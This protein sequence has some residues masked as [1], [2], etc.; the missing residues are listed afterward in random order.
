M[1]PSKAAQRYQSKNMNGHGNSEYTKDEIFD[2]SCIYAKQLLEK[3]SHKTLEE[4]AIASIPK[5]KK[6]DFKLGKVLGRGTFGVVQE[7]VGVS[8]KDD[9]KKKRYVKKL[10]QKVN[11]NITVIDKNTL[12][13]LCFR[14][15]GNSRFAIK[16]LSDEVMGDHNVCYR[17]ILD[18]NH[19]RKFLSIIDHPCILKIRAISH[20][21]PFNQND[22]ILMD[23]LEETLDKKIV[24]WKRKSMRIGL[25][26]KKKRKFEDRL[27]VAYDLIS[28]VSYLHSK[29]ILHRDLKPEN[30]GFGYKS[31]LKLFDFG[32]ARDVNDLDKDEDGLYKLTGYTGSCRY[33]AP[34]IAKNKPY[35]HSVDVYSYAILLWQLFALSKPYENYTYNMHQRYVVH[36]GHRP[37][38]EPT[39]PDAIKLLMK[40]CWSSKIAKRPSASEVLAVIQTEIVQMRDGDASAFTA[41]AHVRRNSSNLTDP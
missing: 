40:R 12:S 4:S 38:I 15:K 9:A 26:G 25:M 8:D 6:E 32:L 18:M 34:E 13:D 39:W 23:K 2:A 7:V 16:F 28:A 1:S 21:G 30:I 3:E 5:L 14:E 31:D 27:L 24:Y 29:N 11:D 19:D 36:E 41:S 33:M 22:F 17:A 37:K 20:C 10:G 35:N